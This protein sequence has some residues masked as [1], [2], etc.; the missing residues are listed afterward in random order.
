MTYYSYSEK[1]TDLRTI[2][3]NFKATL[4]LAGW[5]VTSSG[6]GTSGT[7][8]ATGDNILSATDFGSNAWFVA[9]HP[10][11]DGYQR[12][13]CFQFNS[14]VNPHSVRIKMAWAPYSSGTPSA[15][16]V[17]TSADQQILL[18]SG[19]DAS[20]SYASLFTSINS[21]PDQNV[22]CMVGDS[23]EKY[24]FYLFCYKNNTAPTDTSLQALIMMQYLNSTNTLDI[25]PYVY[26]AQNAPNF[27][28]TASAWDGT[29]VTQPFG[30]YKKG[31]SGA[32][33][34]RYPICYYGPDGSGN[35]LNQI[36]SNP[37]DSTINLMPMIFLRT[38][39]GQTGIKGVAAN[40]NVSPTS[41]GSLTTG[42]I[43]TTRDRIYFGP[44]LLIN[45]NGSSIRV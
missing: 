21:G 8:N 17:P 9:A 26:S 7:Y 1:V 36:G 4:K 35:I 10:T 38:T 5:V 29:T 22:Y 6:T 33:F 11:L 16:V 30:W 43:S 42:S 45:Y 2:Y 20:P 13:L 37:Y 12:Y 32:A 15:T 41:R 18:G 39:G 28:S 14:T 44:H 40:M 34:I 31:L 27:S 19:T 24:S 3:F 25:D 23:T